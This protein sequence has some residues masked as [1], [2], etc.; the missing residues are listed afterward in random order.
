MTLSD[1]DSRHCEDRECHTRHLYKRGGSFDD[2]EWQLCHGTGVSG[3]RR[4]SKAEVA[5]RAAERSARYPAGTAHTDF[6]IYPVYQF[7]EEEQKVA[8]TP[9]TAKTRAQIARQRIRELEQEL[10]FLSQFPEDN[11]PEHTVLLTQRTYTVSVPGTV[12]HNAYQEERIYTYVLLKTAGQWWMTGTNGHG[13]NG[14][15]WD[16]VIEFIGEEREPFLY[17]V[18]TGKSVLLGEEELASNAVTGVV[19]AEGKIE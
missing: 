1:A 16:K 7:N 14:A 19:N 11:F 5:R 6:A 8:K 3:V 9:Q 13:I 12:T 18:R 2:A 4:R 10:A 15:S 17:D